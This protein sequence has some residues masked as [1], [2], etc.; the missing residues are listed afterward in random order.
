M[1]RNPRLGRAGG[2]VARA[3]FCLCVGLLAACQVAVATP[4]DPPQPTETSTPEPL[5]T[6]TPSPQPLP[7][8][9]PGP[10]SEAEAVAL[11]EEQLAARSVDLET[12]RLTFRKEPRI[13]S[14]RFTS[15]YDFG[16]TAYRAHS[17]L[18]P[19][20]VSRIGVRVPSAVGDGIEVSII[21]R[22]SEEVGLHVISIMGSTLEAWRAGDLSDQEFVADWT[23][24]VIPKQ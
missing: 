4:T 10:L 23:V 19:L 16:S 13:L 5:P 14:L 9:T 21:P 8:A 24:G 11:I 15:P 20:L 17:V 6:S 18:V 12:V 7:T 3:A 2:Y 1:L 22:G